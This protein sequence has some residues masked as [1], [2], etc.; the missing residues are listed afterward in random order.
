MTTPVPFVCPSLLRFGSR[1]FQPLRIIIDAPPAST[2][3]II[4]DL[5]CYL[6][7]TSHAGMWVGEW[8]EKRDVRPSRTSRGKV[9]CVLTHVRLCGRYLPLS[10]QFCGGVRLI[11][12]TRSIMVMWGSRTAWRHPRLATRATTSDL[13][14]ARVGTHS[15]CAL[16]PSPAWTLT[17]SPLQRLPALSSKRCQSKRRRHPVRWCWWLVAQRWRR[18]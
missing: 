8:F 17:S 12:H 6:R 3:P 2:A 10:S 5:S 11:G 13:W 7:V 14:W 1:G 18:A 16:R 4:G 9:L 15:F